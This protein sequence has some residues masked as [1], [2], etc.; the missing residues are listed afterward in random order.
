MSLITNKTLF[1]LNLGIAFYFLLLF[2]NA[3]FFKIEGEFIGFLQ[4]LVTL[5]LLAI[6]IF[7]FVLSFIRFFSLK[8]KTENTYCVLSCIIISI[9]T[10]LT[11]GSF[12]IK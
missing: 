6:E 1:Y 11:I 3:Y 10:F 7:L 12:F 8:D 2:L 4:E 9:S 5:P